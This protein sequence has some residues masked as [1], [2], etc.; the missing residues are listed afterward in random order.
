MR[1]SESSCE[2]CLEAREIKSIRQALSQSLCWH[3]TLCSITPFGYSL[4]TQSKKHI[5]ITPKA[6]IRNTI[7]TPRKL[8]KMPLL[9]PTG[10][11]NKKSE[12]PIKELRS[13][14]KTKYIRQNHAAP[15]AIYTNS[16]RSCLSSC[17]A[18]NPSP[19]R[20]NSATSEC[21]FLFGSS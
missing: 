21:G 3:T 13:K 10:A 5:H 18:I 11:A 19:S 8:F 16:G 1:S 17:I 20:E 15:S 14:K 12:A 2:S 4:H 7:S 6:K 9:A